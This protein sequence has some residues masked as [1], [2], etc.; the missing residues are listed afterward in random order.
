L[1]NTTFAKVAF[2]NFDLYKTIVKHRFKFTRING[3][4]YTKHNPKTLNFIPPKDLMNA[5][6]RDYNIM[7]ENMIY[8]NSPFSFEELISKLESL[9][10]KINDLDWGTSPF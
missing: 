9:N 4:D 5:W 2:E 1:A 6:R 8:E 7:L 3:I 10:S